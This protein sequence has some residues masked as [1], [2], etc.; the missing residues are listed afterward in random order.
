MKKVLHKSGI[1]RLALQY[2]PPKPSSVCYCLGRSFFYA[3]P[4]SISICQNP[5]HQRLTSQGNLGRPIL[6]HL[7][8]SLSSLLST[9]RLAIINIIFETCSLCLPVIPPYNMNSLRQKSY[10]V[11][12]NSRESQC[13]ATNRSKT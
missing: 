2:Y 12:V 11:P 3:Y 8:L 10:L 4:P 13:L 7:I 1:S 6:S 9:F 5:I